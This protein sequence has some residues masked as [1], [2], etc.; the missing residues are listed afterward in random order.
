[1]KVIDKSDINRA[2][3]PCYFSPLLKFFFPDYIFVVATL[4][5][6]FSLIGV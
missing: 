5:Q 4:M 2:Q 3:L 6:Y 1:M